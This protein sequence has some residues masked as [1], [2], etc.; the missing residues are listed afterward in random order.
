MFVKCTILGLMDVSQGIM[1]DLLNVLSS[2]MPAEHIVVMP[3][4]SDREEEGRVEP[5]RQ[6][7]GFKIQAKSLAKMDKEGRLG[8]VH[9]LPKKYKIIGVKKRN[10]EGEEG[11]TLAVRFKGQAKV[12]SATRITNNTI[13]TEDPLSDS[14]KSARTQNRA[15]VAPSLESPNASPSAQG[16]SGGAQNYIPLEPS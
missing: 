11:K 4:I 3:D 15:E 10:E 6:R 14:G 2:V 9:Q 5:S 7:G 16:S 8:Q 1:Q 12:V 13:D